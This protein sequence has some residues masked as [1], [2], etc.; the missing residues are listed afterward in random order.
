MDLN[1]NLSL[2]RNEVEALMHDERAS[3]F[4]KVADHFKTFEFTIEE[5]IELMHE[6]ADEAEAQAIVVRLRDQIGK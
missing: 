6:I 2:S 1:Y 4:R 3:A 5:A